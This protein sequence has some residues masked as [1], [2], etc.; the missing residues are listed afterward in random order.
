MHVQNA[1]QQLHARFVAHTLMSNLSLEEAFR[2]LLPAQMVAE[3][4]AQR[5]DGDAHYRDVTRVEFEAQL[6]PIAVDKLR[7]FGAVTHTAAERR[8]YQ[9]FTC[10]VNMP[11]EELMEVINNINTRRE[12]HASSLAKPKAKRKPMSRMASWFRRAMRS[13]QAGAYA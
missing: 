9:A 12:Q 13:T 1:A 5:E 7:S 6:P 2:K 10:I 8:G 4:A 3:F 11:R